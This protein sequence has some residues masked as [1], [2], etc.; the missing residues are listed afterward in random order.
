MKTER[1]RVVLVIATFFSITGLCLAALH[2]TSASKLRSLDKTYES[3]KKGA[4]REEVL[5]LLGAPA[6]TN[7]EP[8]KFWDEAK[9]SE[10]ELSKISSTVDYSVQTFF[11][12]V[13]FRF[14]FDTNG[15]LVGKHRYD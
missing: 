12:P 2:W 14:S 13:T 15:A 7:P 6:A 1:R 10:A 4:T 11:L 3:F 9:L 8:T 5:A